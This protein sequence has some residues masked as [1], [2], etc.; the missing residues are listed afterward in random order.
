MLLHLHIE[1]LHHLGREVQDGDTQAEDDGEG[2]KDGDQQTRPQAW[3]L[4][5]A[6]SWT[7][8]KHGLGG[9]CRH[10]RLLRSCSGSLL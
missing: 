3:P 6:S 5:A 1:K 10:S 9:H 2:D 4:V 8:S 7:V